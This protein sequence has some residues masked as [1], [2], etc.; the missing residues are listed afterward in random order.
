MSNRSVR[1]RLPQLLRPR[2]SNHTGFAMWRMTD[3]VEPAAFGCPAR[4]AVRRNRH[5]SQDRMEARKSP[6]L[7]FKLNR[8]FTCALTVTVCGVNSSV[9]AGGAA[10]AIADIARIRGMTTRG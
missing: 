8:A 2:F 5:D 4:G 9:G 6:P 3:D 7:Y 10:L 1:L